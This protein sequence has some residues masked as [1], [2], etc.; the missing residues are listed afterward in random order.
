[1]STENKFNRGDRVRKIKGHR[2]GGDVG[3]RVLGT[4]D[5]FDSDQRF[6]NVQHDEGWVM[7]FREHELEL[8]P[9]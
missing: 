3:A 7:H 1:M 6:V 2:F 9:Q 8:V 4:F 5:Y